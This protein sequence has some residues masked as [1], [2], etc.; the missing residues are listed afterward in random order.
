MVTFGSPANLLFRGAFSSHP[1]P[2]RLPLDNKS[3]G[4]PSPSHPGFG[5][6]VQG[7]LMAQKKSRTSADNF[8]C[9]G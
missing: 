5:V 7:W 6:S 8:T 2:T 4:F 1:A 9:D 3:R